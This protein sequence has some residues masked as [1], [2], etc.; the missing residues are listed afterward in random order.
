MANGAFAIINI[1]VQPQSAGSLVNN[2]T[3]TATETDA[4]TN[5]NSVSVP[6]TIETPSS[7]PSM[8]DPNLSVKTVVNGLSQPT[9]MAFI[10]NNDF[11]VFEK[12]TGKVQRVTN[13]VVQS[14]A[15]LD[16]AVNSGSERGGLGL[17]L[18]P[19]F[20]FN[21][22]VYLYWTE[23]ST[24]V[25][26]TNLAEVPILGN[27]V[28]RYIWNASTLTF[29]RNI[30]KLRA[31]QAD[32]NQQLRGNHNGGV[33]RFGPDGKLFI[34]MGDNG[35]RGYLQNLLC[36]PTTGACPGPV[37]PDDQFGGPEPDNNHLT[38][39]ILRLNDD[40]STPTDN[41]FSQII[42]I[43]PPEVEANIRKIFAY[44]VRNGFGLGFD[45]YSGNLWDQE[46]GD[47]A[48]DE[49]NRITAGSNNGWVQMMGPSS[50][51]A[52]FKQIETTYGAGDLQQLRWP[53]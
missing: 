35:R 17:A 41:P 49:M 44:G 14:P 48:F 32:A 18:H 12:N 11:F 10:G 21:G 46:Y 4:D 52:Q 24:G 20:A 16:L 25:D 3:V 42:T 30:I 26:T 39:F 7:G 9:S 53:P 37:V 8:T 29:D 23:S 28:D 43:Q 1:L 50:R 5:D 15:P 2:A 36:G 38:G 40:G 33:L 31:F 45:P 6:T 51:V 19:N 27:R 34:L 47:D 13:G 22:Y